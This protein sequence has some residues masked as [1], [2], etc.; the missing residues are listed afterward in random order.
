MSESDAA[1][2]AASFLCICSAWPPVKEKELSA[3]HTGSETGRYVGEGF[4]LPRLD[5]LLLAMPVSGESVVLQ[6]VGRVI[7]EAEGKNEIRVYDYAD[8]HTPMLDR[9]FRKRLRIYKKLGMR[10]Q[11]SDPA[12]KISSVIAKEK[13]A[14]QFI[15]E[16]GQCSKSAVV[17]C[18]NVSEKW[19]DGFLKAVRSAVQNGAR[20]EC[21]MD[22]GSAFAER[23][24][25]AGAAFRFR[26]NSG[27]FAVLENEIVW[28]GGEE[29]LS[30]EQEAIRIVSAD[31]ASELLELKKDREFEQIA[32]FG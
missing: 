28:Y 8:V 10:L 32:L 26:N 15:A 14:E 16:L 19:R 22:D 6:Y 31:A 3:D 9:M 11:Y 21:R 23:L 29:F 27:C 13:A 7:R 2:P 25:E 24:Q 17:F 12:E 4:D 20:C 18:R 1:Q 5:T 30:E